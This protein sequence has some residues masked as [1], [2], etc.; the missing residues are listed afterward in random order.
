VEFSE[1]LKRHRM[2][3]AY[4]PELVPRETLERIVRTIRRAPSAGFSQGQR[5][6]VVTDQQR[7]QAIAETVGEEFYRSGEVESEPGRFGLVEG[8]CVVL[9]PIK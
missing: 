8:K 5:F 6:V 2:V 9:P 7:K 4:Q 1:L 3:R